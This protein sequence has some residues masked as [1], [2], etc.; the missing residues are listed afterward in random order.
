M[1]EYIIKEY[2]IALIFSK[3]YY[4]LISYNYCYYRASLAILAYFSLIALL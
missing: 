3:Q 2:K 4:Y 1:Q